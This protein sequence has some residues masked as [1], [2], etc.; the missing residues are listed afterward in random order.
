M[1][2]PIIFSRLGKR[3]LGFY[4][5][6]RCH[7]VAH[8][9]VFSHAGLHLIPPGRYSSVPY[10]LRS[11][12]IRMGAIRIPSC[13]QGMSMCRCPTDGVLFCLFLSHTHA[14]THT[15]TNRESSGFFTPL[16]MEEEAVNVFFGTLFL[17]LFYSLHP[18]PPSP[19]HP[20]TLRSSPLLNT[21]PRF[22]HCNSNVQT[23][24]SPYT[25][26][27]IKTNLLQNRCVSKPPDGST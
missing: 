16:L 20:S 5:F 27:A 22:K 14:H 10:P 12:R 11:T 4:G 15:H 2:H 1:L 25:V 6:S 26:A 8:V 13:K 19:P 17:S 3:F 23:S 7:H 9:F 21:G 24:R 18:A